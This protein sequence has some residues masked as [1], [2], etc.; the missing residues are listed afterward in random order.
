[1]GGEGHVEIFCLSQGAS[2]RAGGVHFQDREERGT[3]ADLHPQ[4]PEG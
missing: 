2:G 3:G 1:M 4:G